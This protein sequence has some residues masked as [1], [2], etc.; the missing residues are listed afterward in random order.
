MSTAT[1]ACGSSAP[2]YYPSGVEETLR[3][4]KQ[5]E[6][7]ADVAGF[8]RAREIRKCLLQTSS[9]ASAS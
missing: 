1:V 7:H 9:A 5:V 6:S 2:R 4:L 3:V 8:V